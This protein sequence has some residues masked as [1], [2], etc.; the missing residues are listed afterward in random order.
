M[1]ECVSRLHWQQISA[2]RWL[3]QTCHYLP[4]SERE[5]VWEKL[6]AMLTERQPASQPSTEEAE[7][8]PPKK[9][10]ALL[11]L[12]SE[13]DSDDEVLAT[14]KTLGR[15]RTCHTSSCHT[16][17]SNL[18]QIRLWDW[19]VH[20]VSEKSPDIK[21]TSNDDSNGPLYPVWLEMKIHLGIQSM[22]QDHSTPQRVKLVVMS[23]RLSVTD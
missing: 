23:S 13:L 15:Y 20:F 8:E 14:D 9:K 16:V 1:S 17:S 5:D 4:R 3:I 7:P 11:L 12:G 10:M 18:S 6:S 22:G 19:T 21:I 2:D